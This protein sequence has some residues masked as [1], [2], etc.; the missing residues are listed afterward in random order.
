MTPEKVQEILQKCLGGGCLNLNNLKAILSGKAHS[1][2]SL[3]KA[4][5]FNMEPPSVSA[6]TG[7]AEGSVRGCTGVTMAGVRGISHDVI[8]A[9]LGE[10]F[11]M[12]PDETLK[13]LSKAI[14]EEVIGGDLAE[15]VEEFIG[16]FQAMQLHPV[17]TP[18]TA[19]PPPELSPSKNT[20]VPHT[21][22]PLPQ[23]CT[24]QRDLAKLI[25]AC[26]AAQRPFELQLL[27]F[28]D[29]GGQ[30]QF[31]EVLPAFLHNTALIILVLKL[32]EPLDAYSEPEFCDEKGVTHKAR[33]TSLLS[34]EEILE[35]QV[36]TLQAKPSGLSEG[37]EG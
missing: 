9:S 26:P 5:P 13:L 19:S 12:S 3:T 33:C 17:N 24:T 20:I 1:G 10:W 14:H 21:P 2:K 27:H 34:N 28:V 36:H 31:H 32:S 15:V 7:V 25:E 29:S 8:W 11:Q 6:N 16:R 22:S 4:R 18:S 23:I 37:K 35:H 30:P